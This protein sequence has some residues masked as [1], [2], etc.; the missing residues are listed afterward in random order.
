MSKIFIADKETSFGRLFKKL[1][2]TYAIETVCVQKTADALVFLESTQAEEWIGTTHRFPPALLLPEP[3]PPPIPLKKLADAHMRLMP[4]ETNLHVLAKLLLLD[5]ELHGFAK[6]IADLSEENQQPMLAIFEE[7]RLSL[8]PVYLQI[9]KLLTKLS[10]ALCSKETLLELRVVVHRLAGSSGSYGFMALSKAAKTLELAIESQKQP[11]IQ[12]LTNEFLE[13]LS[14]LLP[15]TPQAPPL[16]KT[17]LFCSPAQQT[18]NQH[19]PWFQN[20]SVNTLW[21]MDWVECWKMAQTYPPDAAILD[22]DKLPV[23]SWPQL[24]EAL[25][26]SPALAALPKHLLKPHANDAERACAAHLNCLGPSS[27]PS[28]FEELKAMLQALF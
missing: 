9:H 15:P 24:F 7:F 13:M 5:I 19:H 6:S 10:Q 28:T 11:H 8:H 22:M 23:E 26:T 21:A 25:H 16:S 18:R 2:D 12:T 17:L 14:V 3:F 20:L 4:R 1:L 27:T